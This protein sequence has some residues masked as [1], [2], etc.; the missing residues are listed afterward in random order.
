MRR[1]RDIDQEAACQVLVYSFSA[2]A[3]WQL[4]DKALWADVPA[5]ASS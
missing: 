1:A 5:A 3:V 2:E 4:G